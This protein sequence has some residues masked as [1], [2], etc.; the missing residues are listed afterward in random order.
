MK[1]KECDACH[2]CSYTRWNPEEQCMNQIDVYECWGVR[3]PFEISDINRE[4]TEY[5]EKREQSD[6]KAREVFKSETN[7][8]RF[9]TDECGL[10]ITPSDIVFLQN[11][12]RKTWSEMLK[13]I[14]KDNVCPCCGRKLL[15]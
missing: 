11:G 15:E 9:G 7:Y 8:L 14:D 12:K 1:C 2:L 6:K 3:E 5:P 4:C 10:E 13:D